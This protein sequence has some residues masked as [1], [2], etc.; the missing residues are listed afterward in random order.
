MFKKISTR[1]LIIILLV[2]TGI[3]IADELLNKDKKESSFS[4]DQFSVD[5]LEI[6]RI[7]LLKGTVQSGKV[8]L[9]KSTHT[10][11]LKDHIGNTLNSDT[12]IINNALK[13]IFNLNV[14]RM[15]AKNKEKWKEYSV[16]DSSALHIAL[17][18]NNGLL[19]EFLIGRVNFDQRTRSASN[20]IRLKDDVETFEAEGMLSMSIPAHINQYR[21]KKLA[22]FGK[23]QINKMH[24]IHPGDSSFL[25]IKNEIKWVAK[26]KAVDSAKVENYL[27][28]LSSLKSTDFAN[29]ENVAGPVLHECIIEGNIPAIKIR[30]FAADSINKY[31]ITSSMN[32]GVF[33]S[34]KNGLFDRIFKGERQFLPEE[35]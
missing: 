20:Y 24:F 27:N 6:S 22:L 15:V 18:T 34:A 30:A 25:L 33:F 35:N 1:V 2:L 19:K 13:Q 14:Q 28:S 8:I 11:N 29:I 21:N 10:W 31:Y 7:E 12:T 32:P 4:T 26:D 5:S 3:Y 23:E 9:E 17:Y 16:D